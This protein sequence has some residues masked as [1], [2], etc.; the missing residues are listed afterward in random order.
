M[1]NKIVSALIQK[2]GKKD[3]SI[4][5][6]INSKDIFIIFF[7]KGINLLRGFKIKFFLRHSG[8]MLFL[9]RNCRIKH[10]SHIYLG[11]TVLIGDNVEINALS[12]HG[13]K[14]GNNFSIHRNSII[15]CTG[16]LRNIGE[17]IVIGNNVGIAQNCFIQVRGKVTIGNNVIFGPGVSVF[18]ESHNYSDTNLY[19]NEQGETRIGVLIEDGVWVGSGAIILDGVTIGN[20]SIIAAGSVVNKSIPP[21]SI[22]VGVPA[23]VVKSI[24]NN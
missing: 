4:D 11:K 21:F 16:V 7:S 8:G 23:K 12:K 19:I 15:E 5:L 9:G 14:I 2:L 3:Y 17:G 6:E 18:S 20:N 13:V 22:A 10:K 24:I 1:L